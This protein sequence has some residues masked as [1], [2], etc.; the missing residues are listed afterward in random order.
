MRNLKTVISFALTLGVM[1]SFGAFNSFAQDL[2][3]EEEVRNQVLAEYQNDYMFNQMRIHDFEAAQQYI[4]DET[5]K[6]LAPSLLS[7]SGS[8]ASCSVP[9]IQQ[10]TNTYCGYAS[11]LQV[12]YGMNLGSSVSGS[13]YEAQQKTLANLFGK[14]SAEVWWIV[15]KLNSYIDNTQTYTF[16]VAN[17]TS[18]SGC[19]TLS[20]FTSHV[21]NSL[22]V[23]RPPILHAYTGKL[24]Y[25]QGVNSGHYVVVDYINRQTNLVEI[26]DP[27]YNDTYYGKHMV[28]ISNAFSSISLSTSDSLNVNNDLRYLISV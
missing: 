26:S 19:L 1:T 16:Y 13:T 27:H 24:S 23:N 9:N 17:N 14:S 11:M 18:D 2:S 6:R 10:S 7:V 5:A 8:A 20:T 3:T 25:Y 4:S 12:L 21:F 22:A 28:S 15:D